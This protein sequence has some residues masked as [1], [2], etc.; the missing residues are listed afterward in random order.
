MS[1]KILPKKNEMKNGQELDWE[2]KM[3]EEYW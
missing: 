2:T 1:L 3:H